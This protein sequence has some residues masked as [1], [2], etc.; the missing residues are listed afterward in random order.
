M[1][2]YTQ[3]P[4]EW[5]RNPL[6]QAFGALLG[7]AVL[8]MSFFLGIVVLAVLV[9]LAL[10]GG[11]VL[12]LRMWWLKR[13]LQREAARQ[14]DDATVVEGEYSVVERRRRRGP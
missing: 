12:A 10:I 3:G 1:Q 7:L 4:P 11:S 2:N 14:P 13:R 6:A 5:M 8:V 9:G